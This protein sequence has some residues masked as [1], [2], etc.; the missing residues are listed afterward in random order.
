MWSLRPRHAHRGRTERRAAR[1]SHRHGSSPAE[2]SL[3]AG[4]E[5]PDGR[6]DLSPGQP[7]AARDAP[8]GV[9]QA[10]L[11]G[12]WGTSPGLSLIN[13]DLNRLIPER[14]ANVIYLAGPG[15]SGP[16]IVANVC[17]EGTY[18]KMCPV[19]RQD[20]PGLRRLFRQFSTPGGIPSR[21][22]VPA[23]GSIHESGELGYVLAHAFGAT[24][25]NPDLIV[26]AVVGDGEAETAPACSRD[27]GTRQ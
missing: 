21:L 9:Y 17:L 23:P 1:R 14:N 6:P 11:L 2:A 5:L 27:V 3:L 8:R 19:V 13:V 25:E 10:R 7:S 22:S 12:H 4:R 24:F 15:H 18:S 26:A 16:A 20:V